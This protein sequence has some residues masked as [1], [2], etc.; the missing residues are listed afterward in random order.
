METKNNSNGNGNGQRLTDFINCPTKVFYN[1]D[2]TD[3]K[4]AMRDGILD[5]F[6]TDF[7]YIKD[8]KGKIH[9]IPKNRI[10]RS[11][12]MEVGGV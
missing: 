9:Q 7:L 4:P 5:S 6:D 2:S 3:G 10:I 8:V 12:F 11:E 1:D